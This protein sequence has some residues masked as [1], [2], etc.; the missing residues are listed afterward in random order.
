MIQLMIKHVIQLMIRTT[1]QRDDEM[2]LRRNIRAR[3]KVN[4]LTHLGAR[5][6]IAHAFV[7]DAREPTAFIHAEY[8]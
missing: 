6:H 8:S 7:D 4:E 2:V 3:T 1:I 5:W